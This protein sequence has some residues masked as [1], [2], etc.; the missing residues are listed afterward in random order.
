MVLACGS[1]RSG[2]APRPDPHGPARTLITRR[3]DL[4]LRRHLDH[5]VDVQRALRDEPYARDMR[6]V[7]DAMRG[8]RQLSL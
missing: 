1:L 2:F 8:T 3:I 5:G 7:R 6:L 4:P